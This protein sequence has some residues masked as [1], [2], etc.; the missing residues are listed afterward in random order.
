MQEGNTGCC[1]D[2]VRYMLD[3]CQEIQRHKWIE[4]EKVGRDLGSEA[5]MDWIA[6]YA[7][8]FRSAAESCGRYGKP[9]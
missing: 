6:K 2:Q 3:Q 7:G 5:I 1:W 4:S 9:L 8:K